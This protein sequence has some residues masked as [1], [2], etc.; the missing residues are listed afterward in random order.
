[1]LVLSSSNLFYSRS[2]Q[3]ETSVGCFQGKAQ[4]MI[5]FEDLGFKIWATGRIGDCGTREAV[6]IPGYLQ[7]D[8][9]EPLRRDAEGGALPRER[10]CF[11]EL[12]DG[13]GYEYSQ[14][15]RGST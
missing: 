3:C 13:S 6:E 5:G 12:G 1:M 7:V 11:L 15:G 4:E 8:G 14:L 10:N 2:D 9:G